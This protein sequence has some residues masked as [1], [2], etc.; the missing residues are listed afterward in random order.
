[1]LDL[2]LELAM[3]SEWL[4]ANHLTLNVDKTK[5]IVFGSKLILT[6]KPDLNLCVDNK[7][8]ERVSTIN[9]LGML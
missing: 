6:L 5:Y 2:R 8:I 1:M 7:K 3:V 4:R 9:Y